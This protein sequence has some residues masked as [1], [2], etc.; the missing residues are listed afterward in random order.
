MAGAILIL[1]ALYAV[2]ILIVR[3]ANNTIELQQRTIRERTE[4]LELLSAQMLKTEESHKKK[5]AFELHEGV[6]QTLAPSS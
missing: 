5:I 1:S 3:R 4:T 6:A 2:L